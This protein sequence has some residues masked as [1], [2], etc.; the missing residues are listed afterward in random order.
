MHAS[1]NAS[2]SES[3]SPRRLLST[4]P[5][6]SLRWHSAMMRANHPAQTSESHSTRP[7]PAQAPI[8]LRGDADGRDRQLRTSASAALALTGQLSHHCR[9]RY[10]T[11]RRRQ[12][13]APPQTIN[14]EW[15]VN[16][17]LRFSSR[18]RHTQAERMKPPLAAQPST[19]SS[20]RRCRLGCTAGSHSQ[21]RHQLRF[22]G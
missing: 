7:V 14:C 9:S 8:A 17:P 21:N 20:T 13:R 19:H 5:G 2:C 10:R 11:L 6:I 15:K 22:A 16:L 12:V 18:Y 3:V 1:T 4:R